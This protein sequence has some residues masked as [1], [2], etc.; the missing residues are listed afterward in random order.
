MAITLQEAIKIADKEKYAP[1]LTQI[2]E[3][4]DRYVMTYVYED[5]KLLV[6]GSALYVMKDTGKVGAFFPPDYDDNYYDS[7]VKIPIPENIQDVS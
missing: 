5:G 7:G 1:V 2:T 6:C 4:Q 3:Y